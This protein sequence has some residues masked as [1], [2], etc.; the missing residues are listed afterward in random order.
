MAYTNN[1]QAPKVRRDAAFF[2]VRHGVRVAARRFG[3]SPGTI[4]KW[5][6]RARKIGYHPIPTKSPRPKKHPKTLSKKK[7][8]AIV[9]TRQK[10]KRSAEVVHAILLEQGIEVSLSSVKRTLDRH[11]LIKKRSPWKRYHPPSDRPL[12]DHPG[13][14]V[15][16]DTIHLMRS[17]GTR[18]YIFTLIDLYSRWAHAWATERVNTRTALLFVKRAQRLAPFLFECIQTDHGPEFSAS[19]TDRVSMRHRH[20]RV[21]KP[22]DNAHVERFNRTIQ[23]E[24]VHKLPVDVY[25]LNKKLPEYLKWYNGER[26]HFGLKLKKP[27]QILEECFQAID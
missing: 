8:D 5:V 1:P 12:A 16:A 6:K 4:T 14:L 21:R 24:L 23:T 25:A 19:F 2:A 17:D 27:D 10:V 22:N 9:L 26:H 3:V 13:A 7:V 15:Q 11:H 20:S 18:I